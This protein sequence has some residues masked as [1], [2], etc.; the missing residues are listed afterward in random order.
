MCKVTISESNRTSAA[1]EMWR[2]YQTALLSAVLEN[3]TDAE[4]ES[5]TAAFLADT[6][7]GT[8]LLVAGTDS[9]VNEKGELITRDKDGNDVVVSG[10]FIFET[11]NWTTENGVDKTTAYY[12]APADV[13]TAVRAERVLQYWLNYRV[14]KNA[15]VY[16]GINNKRDRAY[17]NA[18]KMQSAALALFEYCD[19]VPPRFIEEHADV[20]SNAVRF[21]YKFDADVADA[22]E[23]YLKKQA[24]AE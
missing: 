2:T 22:F 24:K 12:A 11:L 1:A 17:K 10:A 5:E 13:N 20:Y 16:D 6:K 8:L 21:G 9:R 18:D 23:S 3:A 7:Q 19:M 15:D 4:L 14:R